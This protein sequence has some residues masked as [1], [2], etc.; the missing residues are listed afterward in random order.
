MSNQPLLGRSFKKTLKL[1]E[2]KFGIK[3]QAISFILQYSKA[4]N[5]INFLNLHFS[6]EKQ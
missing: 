2:V 3:L 4:N 1:N 6:Y 5:V